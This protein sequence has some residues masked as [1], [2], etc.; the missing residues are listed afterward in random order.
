MAHKKKKQST[1]SYNGPQKDRHEKVQKGRPTPVVKT[2]GQENFVPKKFRKP[3]TS[4]NSG[5]S[6]GK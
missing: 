2:P 1:G 3:G 5:S 4:G 6:S